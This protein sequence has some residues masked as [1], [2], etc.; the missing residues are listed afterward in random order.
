MVGTV[1]NPQANSSGGGRGTAI[2]YKVV[3][4]FWGFTSA[5]APGT[6][7]TLQ[8]MTRSYASDKVS[9]YAETQSQPWQE[10]L[11]FNFVNLHLTLSPGTDT[12]FVPHSTPI[13]T[14]FPVLNKQ[15]YTFK[16][17]SSQ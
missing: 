7:T 11:S 12:G 14:V 10:G 8:L 1:G 17:L 3:L 5:Q 2:I 15:R 4:S 9:T 6:Q 16:R 13:F